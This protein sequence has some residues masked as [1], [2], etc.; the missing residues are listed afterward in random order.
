MKLKILFFTWIIMFFTMHC[1]LRT[2]QSQSLTSDQFEHFKAIINALPSAINIS[3][4]VIN[5]K[6]TLQQLLLLSQNKKISINDLI[7]RLKALDYK[8]ETSP[9]VKNIQFT[10]ALYGQITLSQF[11]TTFLRDFI[12]NIEKNVIS[13]LLTPGEI[14][15]FQSV[16]HALRSN[17]ISALITKVSNN[18]TAILNLIQNKKI[19][20][21]ELIT[22]LNEFA[23]EL[24]T[25]S[26]YINSQFNSNLYGPITLAQFSTLALRDFVDKLEQKLALSSIMQ[27]QIM[28]P[29]IPAPQPI[30][31]PIQKEKI[32][33]GLTNVGNSCFMNASLQS[34]YALDKLTDALLEKKQS[35]AYKPDTFG[36]EY[37]NFINQMHTTNQKIVEPRT[38]CM[39]GWQKMKFAPLSQQDNDEFIVALLNELIEDITKDPLAHLIA[40]TWQQYINKSPSTIEKTFL[41]SL[42]IPPTESTLDECLKIF[43]NVEK[44][45]MK[46]EGKDVLKDKQLKIAQT[47]QYLIIHLKRNV[48]KIDPRTN[49][50]ILDPKTRQA[51]MDKIMKPIIFPLENLNLNSYA[52]EGISLPLYRLK[53]MVIHAGSSYGGHYTAYV[54]YGN[55]WYFVNDA[56]VV[57]VSPQEIAKIAAQGFGVGKDQTPTTFFYET[58]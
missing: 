8:L 45:T 57:S 28:L 56:Q 16:I 3:H 37:I 25:K 11:A 2:D 15:E 1:A 40:I 52:V 4:E 13:L 32:P 7:T 14:K 26:E 54:R 21:P 19:L 27:K 33:R 35:G 20:L 44:V 5:L 34:L 46:E 18:L 12:H 31:I 9:V 41:L 53:A 23:F 22:K 36:G 48:P 10:S 47:G 55:N 43:F 29:L 24:E 6:K 50:I 39:R 30:S 49:Q 17:T 51:Q 42:P 58:Q 38:L